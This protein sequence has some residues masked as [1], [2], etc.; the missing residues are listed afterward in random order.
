MNPANSTKKP[1]RL[2]TEI[3]QE[4]IKRREAFKQTPGPK[5]RIGTATCG[6]ASGA[7]DTKLAFEQALAERNIEAHIHTVG[8]VGHCYAEPVVV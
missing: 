8:C 1:D 3:K 6:I 4:A 5:I 7:L 2:F